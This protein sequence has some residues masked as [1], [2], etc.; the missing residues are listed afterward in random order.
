M[1]N[2]IIKGIFNLITS[3]F[4]ALLSPIISLITTLFPNLNDM[5]SNI[6]T[7]LNYCF[8]YVRS[9]LSLLCI[10][11]TL[12]ITFFDYIIICYSI[13]LTILA[14]RFA[15]NVYNKLKI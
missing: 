12:I 15:L 4:D 2:T 14:V 7:F 11:D 9:I 6:S 8:T 13:Y 10:S 1:I 3:L 5:F